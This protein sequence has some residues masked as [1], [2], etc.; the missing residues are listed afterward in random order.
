M[1]KNVTLLV[2]K[3]F[4]HVQMKMLKKTMNS[5]LHAVHVCAKGKKIDKP[6]CYYQFYKYLHCVMSTILQYIN[7][8]SVLS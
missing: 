5:T 3:L 2:M 6:K 4:V 8:L 1:R 7:E